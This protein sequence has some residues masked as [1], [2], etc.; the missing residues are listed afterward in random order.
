MTLWDPLT[1]FTQLF[2]IN[3][4]DVHFK[5]KFEI[6]LHIFGKKLENIVTYKFI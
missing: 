6:K 1:N 2:E 5:F 3:S 4:K